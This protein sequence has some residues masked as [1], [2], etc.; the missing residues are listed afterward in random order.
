M[1]AFQQFVKESGSATCTKNIVTQQTDK[2]VKIS[3]HTLK[4]KKAEEE[5]DTK[6]RSKMSSSKQFIKEE[7]KV[8]SQASG[9]KV[10][11]AAEVKKKSE[12]STSQEITEQQCGESRFLENVTTQEQIWPVHGDVK[13]VQSVHKPPHLRSKVSIDTV[14]QFI[15]LFK[16]SRSSKQ[17]CNGSHKIICLKLGK[18]LTVLQFQG[19]SSK[20]A[21]EVQIRFLS[22]VRTCMLDVLT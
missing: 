1:F 6:N 11:A 22:A 9:N 16:N 18:F 15:L 12:C 7:N 8:I 21:V 3:A 13:L 19:C 20:K 4:D 2:Q 17:T 14:L 10:I 5:T